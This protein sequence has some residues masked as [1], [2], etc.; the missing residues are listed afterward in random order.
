MEIRELVRL[1]RGTGGLEPPLNFG[2]ILERERSGREHLVVVHTLN[3][4]LT[5][6]RKFVKDPT[7]HIFQGQKTDTASMNEFLRKAVKRE[8]SQNVLRTDPKSIMERTT[9]KDLWQSVKKSLDT[10]ESG[11]GTRWKEA[12]QTTYPVLLDPEDIGLIHFEP[13]FLDPKQVWAVSRVLSE[14]DPRSEPYFRKIE[15]ERKPHYLAYK[16]ETMDRVREH[17][18]RLEALK[19]EYVQWEVSDDEGGRS[20]KIPKMKVD[21]ITKVELTPGLQREL[22][23][24]CVLTKHYLEKGKWPDNE[25]GG[26][27]LGDTG[28]TRLDKFDLEKFIEFFAMDLTGTVKGYLASNLAAL[29]LKLKRISWKEASELVV[30]FKIASGAQKFRDRF[31]DHVMTEAGRLPDMVHPK[32]REGRIDLTGLVTFTI[33]PDDAKDFDDA[34]SILREKGGWTIWVHIADVSHYVHPGSMTDME[35][36]FRSTSVYLPTGVLPMLPPVLSEE[37]CSLKEGV[38]R[39]ALSTKMVFNDEMD[40]LHFKQSPSVIMVNGNLDYGTVEKWMEEGRE[41]FCTLNDLTERLE[42][43][44]TRLDLSTPERKVRFR[45]ENDIDV[46]LKRPTPATKAIEVLMVL[47]N[48]CAARFLEDKGLPLPYRVHPLPDRDSAEKFNSACASL[49][50][51]ISIDAAWG[52]NDNEAGDEL[53]ASEDSMVRALLQGGKLNLGALASVPIEDGNEEHTVK[54]AAPEPESLEAAVASYNKALMGIAE[55]PSDAVRDMMSILVL[56]TMP[57]AFYSA[58]NIFHFGL[59]STCYC[60]FTSPIRRYPDIMVHR[61]IKS[62]LAEEGAGPRVDWD[63]HDIDEI[64]SILAGVNEMSE[65]SESWEREMIDV[66]LATKFEMTKELR[67]GIHRGMVVSITPSSCFVQLGDG[68]TEGR[69][70]IKHM[71]PHRLSTDEHGTRVLLELNGEILDD[72]LAKRMIEQGEDEMDVVKLGEVLSFRIQNISIAEG[73]IELSLGEKLGKKLLESSL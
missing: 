69:I 43:K 25:L 42:K 27:G 61:A 24:I 4:E 54:L 31:P 36:R 10:G 56:R 40:L 2:I 50:L 19:E 26:L 64:E 22:D 13:H 58:S 3:G 37:L 17:M 6:K 39:L 9:P 55:I 11:R 12:P 28:I 45:G 70:L 48:E 51:D 38:E 8:E 47:T 5:I 72:E 46:T 32:E 66:A 63:P 67:E 18:E 41:P 21:D 7:G 15:L 53:S 1:K 16:A 65:A 73:H 35:A 20:R 29:L 52:S 57:R 49:G 60:H 33:D 71:S 14:C 62:V 68:M 23:W 59:N 30:K 34:V 44:H